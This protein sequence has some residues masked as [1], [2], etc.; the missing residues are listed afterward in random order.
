MEEVAAEQL[1]DEEEKKN[2]EEKDKKV[3][4]LDSSVMIL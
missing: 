4:D 2:A 1:V 3:V